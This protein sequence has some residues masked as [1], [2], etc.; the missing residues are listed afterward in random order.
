MKRPRDVV[1]ANTAAASAAFD[2]GSDTIAAIYM[3]VLDATTT[4]VRLLS[5]PTVGGTYLPVYDSGGNLCELTVATAAT[6][7]WVFLEAEWTYGVQFVKL[8]CMAGAATDAQSAART[9]VVVTR[10]ITGG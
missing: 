3:P 1:V 8:E 5:S 6:A 9:F 7:Q 4:G 10:T 2:L